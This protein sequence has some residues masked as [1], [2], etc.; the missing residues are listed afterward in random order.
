MTASAMSPRPAVGATSSGPITERVV[1]TR[2]R[3]LRSTTPVARRNTVRTTTSAS[4]ASSS[5]P[6]KRPVCRKSAPSRT[7]MKVNSATMI[8]REVISA[9]SSDGR[10]ASRGCDDGVA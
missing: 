7:T 3:R 5:R 10:A 9:R 8:I 4:L 6:V 1:S 2:A